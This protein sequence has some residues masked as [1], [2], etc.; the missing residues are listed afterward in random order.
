MKQE[1]SN[2]L[3]LSTATD[4]LDTLLSSIEK[5]QANSDIKIQSKRKDGLSPN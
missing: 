5:Q 4:Y 3:A 1:F 2:D